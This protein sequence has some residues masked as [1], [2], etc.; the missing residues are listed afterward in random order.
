MT[1]LSS[2]TL[3]KT[4]DNGAAVAGE[5]ER[6]LPGAA[7]LPE[8]RRGFRPVG[9]PPA[10]QQHHQLRRGR[11]RSAAGSAGATTPR[12]S[13]DALLGGWQLAGINR[14]QRRRAGDASPTR[15]AR[16]SWS[17]ASRRTSAAPTLP[18]QRQL[19]PVRAGRRRRRSPTGSTR[20][21][22]RPDR[23]E[24]AVR[25]R[26]TQHRAR[27]DVLAVRFRGIERVPVGGPAKF[28]FRLEAFNL[29]NRT[30][31]RSP[32]GNRSA[33]AFGTITRYLIRGSCSSES[34]CS[35]RFPAGGML[36]HCV[37]PVNG[38]RHALLQMPTSML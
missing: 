18:A 10:V 29:L 20:R 28:E 9:L 31:F 22:W 36:I 6:Q 12:G 23:S 30:N 19:R 25:E 32:N 33:G 4:K 8:H 3:S 5:P 2:L 37:G 34:S 15:R 1:V 38:P 16:R 17:P 11:C 21:A 14:C 27:T 24:P 7:G 35:G 13:L 26:A